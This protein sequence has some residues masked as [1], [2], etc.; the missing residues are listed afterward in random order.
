ML[1]GSADASGRNDSRCAAIPIK[2]D[3]TARTDQFIDYS[4]TIAKRGRVATMMMMVMVG[5]DSLGGA[6]LASGDVRPTKDGLV[7]AGVLCVA[8]Q[9]CPANRRLVPGGHGG[10]ARMIFVLQVK[11]VYLVFVVA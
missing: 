2:E 1:F 5:A 4:K 7:T 3:K 9:R 10:A 8:T 11:V 6:L